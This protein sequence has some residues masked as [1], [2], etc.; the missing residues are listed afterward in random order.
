M[1]TSQSYFLG[2]RRSRWAALLRI[3]LARGNLAHVQHLEAA[4]NEKVAQRVA[5]EM[6]DVPGNVEHLGGIVEVFDLPTVVVGDIND[7]MAAGA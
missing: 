7:Q 6:K 5:G 4:G 2:A 3:Q 1:R